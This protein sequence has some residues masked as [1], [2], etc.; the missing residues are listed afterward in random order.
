MSDICQLLWGVYNSAY[1]V[2]CDVGRYDIRQGAWINWGGGCTELTGVGSVGG[3]VTWPGGGIS[4][5]GK[6]YTWCGGYEDVEMGTFPKI[7]FVAK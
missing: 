2:G 7:N 1:N 4:Y 3:G 6:L 5:F